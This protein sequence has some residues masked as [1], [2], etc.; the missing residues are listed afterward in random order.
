LKEQVKSL[1]DENGRKIKLVNGLRQERDEEKKRVESLTP[2]VLRAEEKIQRLLQDVQRKDCFIRDLKS[3]SSELEAEQISPD[4][5][6]QLQDKLKRANEEINRK[7]AHV[8]SLKQALEKSRSTEEGFRTIGA[9][10]E[11]WKKQTKQLR[12]EVESLNGMLQKAKSDLDIMRNSVLEAEAANAKKHPRITRKEKR[13]ARLTAERLR[14]FEEML[15][16]FIHRQANHL[17]SS[18]HAIDFKIKKARQSHRTS[19]LKDVK[20]IP[21]AVC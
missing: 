17:R 10:C 2:S 9:E 21:F 6:L 4:V 20:D 12:H 1:R 15:R 18:Q 14:S 8:L 16:H 19:V 13:I 5:H 3:K 11:K 7:E